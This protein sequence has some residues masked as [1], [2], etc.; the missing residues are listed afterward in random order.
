MIT[1]NSLR[2]SQ[3][4]VQYTVLHAYVSEGTYATADLP[5]LA[6]TLYTDPVPG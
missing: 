1:V 3:V 2:T 6:I 4:S 5:D